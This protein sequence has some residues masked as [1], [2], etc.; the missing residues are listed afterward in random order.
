MC[1]YNLKGWL[2]KLPVH[3]FKISYHF[4]LFS[5]LVFIFF[6]LC[7]CEK[8]K[9][10][11]IDH[12]LSVPFLLSANLS[13][14]VLNLDTDTIKVRLLGN[15]TYEITITVSGTAFTPISVNPLR[16]FLQIFK[17]NTNSPFSRIDLPTNSINRDTTSFNSEIPFIINRSEVGLVKFEFFAQSQSGLMSNAIQRTLLITRR[18]SRPVIT[19]IF[20]PDSITIGQL[21]SADST[22]LVAVAVADSDG[23]SDILDVF[24]HS[25]KP[26]STYANNGNP[27][28]L[29]DDGSKNIIQ[30]PSGH[31]GDALEGDGIFSRKVLL[32][33]FVPNPN[34]PPDTLYTQRGNYTFIFRALDN[35]GAES[36]SVVRIIKVK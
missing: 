2:F 21:P 13:D 34:P 3:S 30:P 16:V 22:F 23:I 36:D 8:K 17:P 6:F 18:N 29:F 24:F 11:I 28:L 1:L 20:M 10:G 5:I 9:E 26:D 14:Y 4:L 25:I 31:S 12:N 27:I 7:S 15:N 35:S 19:Q 33:S 32:V